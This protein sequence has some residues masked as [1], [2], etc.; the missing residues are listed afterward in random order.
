MRWGQYTLSV[1][2][3][4]HAAR[5]AARRSIRPKRPDPDALGRVAEDL[6]RLRKHRRLTHDAWEDLWPEVLKASAGSVRD[7][8]FYYAAE[9]DYADV[10]G[11]T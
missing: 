3:W 1:R 10:S 11:D 2:R 4:G 8:M 7:A 6:E 9:P 5:A